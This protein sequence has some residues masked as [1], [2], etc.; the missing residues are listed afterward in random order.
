M[1]ALSNH[2]FRDHVLIGGV[3]AALLLPVLGRQGSLLFW[4]ATIFVDIDHYFE[5]L[6]AVRYRIFG[7][8]SMFRF[9][10]ELFHLRHRPE[11]LAMEIFHTAEFLALLAVL[12]LGLG[13]AFPPV[14]WGVLFHMAVDF[15]HLGRYK[16][17]SKRSPS[18]LEYG[19][20]RRKFLSEGKNPDLVYED[21][22]RAAH[23]DPDSAGGRKA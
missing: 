7:F 15:V 1:K 3:A 16:A 9:F 4:L 20:R 13:G 22:L 17:L 12:A 18:L 21:A 8:R 11:F 19:W 14:F 10:E 2:V 5:F 6:S 23:L